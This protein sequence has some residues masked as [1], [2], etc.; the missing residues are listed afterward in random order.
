MYFATRLALTVLLLA[1]TAP[2]ARAARTKPINVTEDFAR[3]EHFDKAL[4]LARKKKAPLAVYLLPKELEYWDPNC[5]NCRS[6]VNAR[7]NKIMRAVTHP[8]AAKMVKV[9]V[10]DGEKRPE[11]L[12]ASR[13]SI[14][15]HGVYF[16]DYADLRPLGSVA[17][18]KTMDELMN[19][20]A[21]GVVELL[22]WKNAAA[23][24]IDAAVKTSASGRLADALKQLDQVEEMDRRASLLVGRNWIVAEAEKP[25]AEARQD[26]GKEE[27]GS[28]VGAGSSG[29]FFA[30]VVT[31]ART[32]VEE[33]GTKLVEEARGLMEKG[34][35][36]RAR[37]TAGPVAASKANL[38]C[39][40]EAKKVMKEIEEK[41]RAKAVKK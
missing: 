17:E 25:S 4:E 20:V 6:E 16:A 5:P 23:A 10:Y 36:A 37:S 34:D 31:A 8:S 15:G 2:A 11:T 24:R 13:L 7:H 19:H 38:A 1:L 28:F 39:V 40:E 14:A 9:V 3:A 29:L 26:K 21:P 12:T 32:K 41:A 30:E 18:G 22:A 33:N 27:T 35:F